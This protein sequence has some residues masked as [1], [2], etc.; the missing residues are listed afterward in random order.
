MTDGGGA[1]IPRTIWTLWYQGLERAPSLVRRC[2][3]SW[4]AHNPGWTVE[5]LDGTS[6]NR[7]VGVEG[8]L[9][10]NR[11][12]VTCQA[13]SDIVRVGLLH[14]RGG[15]WVDAT[16][17]CCRPLDDWLPAAARRGFLAFRDP[18]PDR[19]VA[20]WFLAASAGSPVAAAWRRRVHD[21]WS[22]A[23][24]ANQNSRLVK[25]LALAVEALLKRSAY[26][27]ARFDRFFRA[28]TRLKTYPYYWFH[29]LFARMILE[30]PEM[31]AAWGEVPALS[32]DGPHRVQHHGVLRP[33]S[34]ALRE[35]ISR[36]EAPFYKL[37]WK[38]DEARVPADCAQE[39]LLAN[40]PRGPQ[41]VE[42]K[43]EP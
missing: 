39:Y 25:P 6:I 18:G 15:V 1:D 21:Y 24:F 23:S 17:F 22:S 34:A 43:Q 12:W 41:A 2:V 4:P 10:T 9:G 37:T 26:R 16:C 31:A 14:E 3:A 42:E 33:P 28:M 38:I 5:V 36:R 8:A 11:P 29:Y 13:L 35:E 30:E 27:S 20:T 7:F 40:L 32:A 19:P